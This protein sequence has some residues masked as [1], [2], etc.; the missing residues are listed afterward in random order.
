MVQQGGRS[1]KTGQASKTAA[2]LKQLGWKIN[3]PTLFEQALTHTSYAHEKGHKRSHYQ[4]L[5]FLGDAVLEL[6]ISD[7]L[8]FTYPNLPE[9]KLTKLRADLVCAASLSRL[10]YEIN[11][12]EYLRLGKGE[13]AGGGNSRPGLLADAVEALIG[14]LYLDQDLEYS[15]QQV[16]ELYRPILGELQEGILRRDYKTLLQEFAQARFGV[17]P[18][19][20]I[21]GESG[22]DHDKLFEAEVMLDT[23]VAGHGRGRS[24]KEAEQDAAREAWGKLTP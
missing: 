1:I 9:G 5:E 21:A 4:R 10:A 19:Y 24:K 12:G 23:Q 6:I 11:L 20:R 22:P 15:K 7:Y 14:A 13:I 8:Y 17:T 16:L 18:A 2:L 3:N